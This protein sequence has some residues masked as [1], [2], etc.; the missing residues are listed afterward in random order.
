MFQIPVGFVQ[1]I[2]TLTGP[3]SRARFELALLG[4]RVQAR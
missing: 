1:I 3:S 4:M 2:I